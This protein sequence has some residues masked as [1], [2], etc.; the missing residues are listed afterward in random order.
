MEF[1]KLTIRSK[2]AMKNPRLL[3]G[4]SGWMDGGQVS[5]GAVGWLIDKLGAK[6]FAEIEPEGFYIYSFPGSMETNTMFRPY[7]RI[8]GG[9]V[10]DYEIPGNMFYY[11]RL[12]DLI[13]LT[14]KEPNLNWTQFAKSIV[15]LCDEFG[16]EAIYYIGS[17]ASLVPHTR[18]A[19]ISCSVSDNKVKEKLAKHGFEFTNYE[20]PAGFVTHLIA[21]CIAKD[22]RMAGFIVNVPAYVH[23]ENPICIETAIRNVGSMLELHIDL[24][25]LRHTSDRFEQ[26]LNKAV[27]EIPELVVNINKLE[28][29]YD[30]ELFDHELGD[31]KDWLVDLGL[32]LD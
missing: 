24:D 8:E 5:T 14:G 32:R 22:V 31:L 21:T 29:I 20:G 23:G 4:L 18:E 10:R 15:E 7:T 16:V 13:I 27:Q 25:D 12:N 11:D 3:I 6:A 2:P 19:R 28:E 9:L 17:V 26:R 30:K 1:D